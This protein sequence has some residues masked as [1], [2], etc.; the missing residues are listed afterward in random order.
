M[1]TTDLV[2]EELGGSSRR[3][4]RWVGR[5]ST[6]ERDRLRLT[7]TGGVGGRGQPSWLA[8]LATAGRRYCEREWEGATPVVCRVRGMYADDRCSLL[9]YPVIY[10]AVPDRLSLTHTHAHT[11][12]L[13]LFLFLL[14][15]RFV[16][17]SITTLF[18]P[19][20]VPFVVVRF[21]RADSVWG[22]DWL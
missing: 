3:R 20:R 6:L 9:F 2:L 5:S 11:L 22:P 15:S 10:S 13:C 1:T 21:C 16:L 18:F 7:P 8:V 14:F 17:S 12:S 19:L 4:C